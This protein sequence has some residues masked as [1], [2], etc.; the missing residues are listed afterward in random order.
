[1]ADLNFFRNTLQLADETAAFDYFV[2]TL[3]TYYNADY[4]VDW[5]K[6]R[7]NVDGI[8]IELHAL[9]ALCGVQIDKEQVGALLE[10][11]PSVVRAFPI[12]LAQ[13]D[14][15]LLMKDVVS[16]EYETFEFKA[17]NAYTS[18][19][20]NHYFEFLR[21]AK[22]Q[23]LFDVLKSVPDYATGVEVGMDTNARKNRSGKVAIDALMPHVEKAVAQINAQG[24]KEVN[25]WTERSY[26][27]LVDSSRNCPIPQGM[28]R[29]KWDYAFHSPTSNK[30]VLVEVNHYGTTG[31]KPDAIA[32]SYIAR[33]R[34]LKEAQLGFIW[35]TDGL[36]WKKM[37]TSL[38]HG[39]KSIDYMTT[40]Q[41]AGQGYLKHALN[42]LL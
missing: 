41:L 15:M 13:R 17:K 31:S 33:Q 14:S 5:D 10:K 36:A 34:D 24:E 7:Q 9:S 29:L 30:W 35:V 12:L 11:V 1:M 19:E 40:I 37:Q 4:Y 6:V 2:Q 26:A 16:G 20:I 3:R 21:D 38:K 42:S 22:L 18:Q 39:F 27:W 23:G 8:S 32:D 25:F 28:H